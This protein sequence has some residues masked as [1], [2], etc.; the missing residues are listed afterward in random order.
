[1]TEVLN[2]SNVVLLKDQDAIVATPIGD[3]QIIGTEYP[4][5]YYFILM[6]LMM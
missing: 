4:H 3:V 6:V 1:M 2:R 5:I